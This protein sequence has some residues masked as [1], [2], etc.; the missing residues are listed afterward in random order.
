MS[1]PA[2]SRS[3][4]VRRPR[5]FG[6]VLFY[7]LL[8]TAR[9]GRAV[10]LR[11]VYATLLLYTLV[12]VHLIWL[13]QYGYGSFEGGF[14]AAL[15][16]SSMGIR[17]AAD[18]AA[19]FFA[20]F[21]AVQ[22]L[23][24][25]LLTPAY[26]SGAIAAEK[27]RGTLTMMLATDLRSHEIV[28]GIFA[29]R[30]ANMGLFLLAGL[31]I[32]S[33]MEFMGGVDPGLVLVG[34][35]ATALTILSLGALGLANSVWSQK[36]RTA[37]FRTYL[38]VI[39]YLAVTSASAELVSALNWGSFPS[40]GNWTSPVTLDN[41][42]DWVDAGNP[43]SAV[44]HLK[45]GLG[46][47][48]PLRAILPGVMAKY[49]R[50]HGVVTIVCLCLA[51]LE[52]RKRTLN[53]GHPKTRKSATEKRYSTPAVRRAW[54]PHW[55]MTAW[56]SLWKE[57][58]ADSG[59]RRGWLGR[60]GLGLL[61]AAV[62]L[63]PIHLF[64]WFGGVATEAL[65]EPM[66][67]WL[68]W[69]S[70]LIGAVMLVQVAVR[71]SGSVCGE[72]ARQTLETLL[73]TPLN[74][75]G[76]LFAKWLA[77]VLSPRGPW[78]VLISVWALA[79]CVGGMEVTTGMLLIS[80]WL[81]FAAAMASLGLYCSVISRSTA[82]AILGVVIGAT[83]LWGA[84]AL[85]AF[86]L[87]ER[88][89]AYVLCP[90]I[91]LGL[92]GY[93]PPDTKQ[94]ALWTWRFAVLFVSSLLLWSGLAAGLWFLAALRFRLAI[95]RT[96]RD[97]IPRRAPGSPVDDL[98]LWSGAGRSG[99]DDAGHQ[100]KRA[101]RPRRHT[102]RDGHL[103]FPSRDNAGLLSE[104]AGSSANPELLP[105]RRGGSSSAPG[106]PG[107]FCSSQRSTVP[108]PGSAAGLVCP[109]QVHISTAPGGGDGGSGSSRSALAPGRTD[110]AAPPSRRRARCAT[111]DQRSNPIT[112]PGVDRS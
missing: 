96:R 53:G 62:F 30:L 83:F 5:V 46:P 3:F 44:L 22:M 51:V 56:P 17:E 40:S 45:R 15:F 70:A 106:R 18:F 55:I 59:Q 50:F 54:M 104:L 57:V 89:D 34:F 103:G 11:A 93:I 95:G 31:P 4:W 38:W 21:M 32:L 79:L 77:S 80:A 26:T 73:L 58:V 48:T 49:A 98:G 76:I 81:I 87:S 112:T 82:W 6:P 110:E 27:E 24:L 66:N 108:A 109:S 97:R 99:R 37:L 75:S 86:N 39:L 92:L 74:P 64:E 13:A 36:P 8:R 105:G 47:T 43:L 91:A 72:Q 19:W 111:P 61:I 107:P 65:K 1:L 41:V 25:L 10:L 28:L 2:D 52:L 68:R 33:M 42:I 84:C 101:K 23:V 60:L 20:I 88:D 94:P 35:A 71:A 63:L 78:L 7:D 14:W 90:P 29:S 12:F 102:N 16:G 100:L 67:F 85:L 69:T 9:R